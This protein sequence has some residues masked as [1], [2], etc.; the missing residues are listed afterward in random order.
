MH[1]TISCP[2]CNRDGDFQFTV[3]LQPQNDCIYK[4]I[5]PKGHE[6]RANILYHHFQLLFEVAINATVDGYYREAIGSFTASYERYMELFLKICS[7]IREIRPEDYESSWKLIAKQSER[8]LGAYVI[9]YLNDFKKPPVILK[10]KSVNLRNQVIHQGYFPDR[11]ETIA[12]GD[13]VLG[14]IRSSV[15]KLWNS[16][17][18]KSELI[19]SINDRGD[20]SNSGPGFTYFPYAMIGTNRDIEREAKQTVDKFLEQRTSD[21]V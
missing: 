10:D 21:S 1:I 6:F 18:H 17:V 2:L 3:P 9:S 19:R 16:E 4:L 15:S 14:I 13:E 12:Y 7:T 11:E 5:C 8:Q 20:F